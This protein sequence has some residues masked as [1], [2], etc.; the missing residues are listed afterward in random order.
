M[1][2]CRTAMRK[3]S[4]Q[5]ICVSRRK[6]I[7]ASRHE[8]SYAQ[9]EG[10]EFVFNKMPVEIVDEGV[11]LRDLIEDENGNQYGEVY[12]NGSYYGKVGIRGTSAELTGICIS[13]NFRCLSNLR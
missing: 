9:L 4:R 2:V 5:V 10:V 7:A 1:D 11:I 8:F 3:G 13:I 12:I 6:K